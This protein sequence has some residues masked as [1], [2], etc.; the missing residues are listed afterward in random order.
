MNSYRESWFYIFEGYKLKKKKNVEIKCV[1]I[2]SDEFV[3]GVR[4]G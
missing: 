1:Q 2:E 4:R 3:V